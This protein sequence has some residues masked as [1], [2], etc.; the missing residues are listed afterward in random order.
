MKV[1]VPTAA[2]PVPPNTGASSIVKPF[3]RRRSVH[4]VGGIGDD[5]REIDEQS[6]RSYFDQDAAGA[7]IS[8]FDIEAGWQHHVAGA[9]AGELLY[10]SRHQV[11]PND[12]TT[13][14]D[15]IQRHQQTHATEADKNHVATHVQS[16]SLSTVRV[17]R[18]TLSKSSY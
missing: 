5:G 14:L 10:A 6:V 11:M 15:Q 16:F 18:S 12:L 2:S 3:S 4:L 17:S 7:Q 9:A 13:D 8:A 1:I